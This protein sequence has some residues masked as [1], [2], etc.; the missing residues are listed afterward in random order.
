MPW[1]YQMDAPTPLFV[2]YVNIF[3]SSDQAVGDP[4]PSHLQISQSQSANNTHRAIEPAHYLIP[5]AVHLGFPTELNFVNV[6]SNSVL[7]S[8]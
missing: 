3:D 6:R 7:K 8:L 2:E 1:A 5:A 4:V